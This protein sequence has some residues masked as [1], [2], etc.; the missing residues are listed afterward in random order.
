MKRLIS[1]NIGIIRL[2]GGTFVKLHHTN[3][4]GQ[5]VYMIL[6]EHGKV[7]RESDHKT[8]SLQGF[9]SAAAAAGIYSRGG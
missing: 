8:C 2:T 3:I 6:L 9:Q 4:A 7:I 1:Q 5:L